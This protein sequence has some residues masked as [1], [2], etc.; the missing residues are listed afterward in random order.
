MWPAYQA[1]L[2]NIKHLL[3]LALWHLT[4]TLKNAQVT[5]KKKYSVSQT[6]T[7]QFTQNHDTLRLDDAE[8]HEDRLRFLPL[9]IKS[10]GSASLTT[11]LPIGQVTNHLNNAAHSHNLRP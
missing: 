6:F 2:C 5:K 11:A 8:L 9:M 3:R 7:R 1:G 10:E 4:I